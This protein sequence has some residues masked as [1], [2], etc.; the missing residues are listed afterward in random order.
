MTLAQSKFPK[1]SLR[2][3]YSKLCLELRSNHLEVSTSFNMLNNYYKP[4]TTKYKHHYIL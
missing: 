3:E 4:I 2:G 1:D